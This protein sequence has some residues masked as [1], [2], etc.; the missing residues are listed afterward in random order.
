M[1]KSIQVLVK[2]NDMVPRIHQNDNISS[3]RRR[4]SLRK[5]MTLQE[6]SNMILKNNMIG[7]SPHKLY[8]VF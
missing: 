6:K 2:S 7:K 8:P 4:I 3:K 5:S 1:S